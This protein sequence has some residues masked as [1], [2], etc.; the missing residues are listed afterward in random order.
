MIQLHKIQ[1]F[2]VVLFNFHSLTVLMC[3]KKDHRSS[4]EEELAARWCPC[5]CVFIWLCLWFMSASHQYFGVVEFYQFVYCIRVG[6][7]VWVCIHVFE[8]LFFSVVRPFIFDVFFV[9][10]FPVWIWLIQRVQ[11]YFLAFLSFTMCHRHGL[12][13]TS[14]QHGHEITSKRE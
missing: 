10:F 1:F 14:N 5:K 9:H 7:V 12:N 11:T 2:V 8:V 6:M 13:N 4:V 3:G